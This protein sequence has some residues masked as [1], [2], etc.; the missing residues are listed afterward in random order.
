MNELEKMELDE[1]NIIPEKRDY[2]EELLSIIRTKPQKEIKEL[3]LDY[4][5]YDIASVI[6]LLTKE[7]RKK[8]YRILGIDAVS[9]VFAYLEDAAE[10]LAEVEIEKAADII[11][12]MDADDALD[13]L[14]E[15]PETQKQEILSLMDEEAQE[16]IK[17]LD[18]YDDD[19]IG[20]K[21]TTNFVSV[22]HTASVKQAMRSLIRQAAENDNIATIYVVDENEVFFGAIELR[23]LVIARE[24]TPLDDIIQP[25]YPY[26]YANEYTADCIE[27]LK[28]YSEDSIPVLDENNHLI[29]VITSSDVVEAVDEE[30]ADDYAKFAGLT[31]EEDLDEPLRKSIA[32][33]IPWLVILLGLGMLVA[34]VIGLFQNLIP[35]SLIIL[36]TFQSLILGMCGNSGTQSL[37]V[38]IRILSDD[39]L[40]FKDR[41]KFVFK[42]LKVGFCNGLI[43]GLIAFA[44]IGL[45]IQFVETDFILEYGVSGFAISAC[46]GVSLLVS[47][48][49]ASLDGTLI[50]MFFKRIGIDPAVA[51][52]PLITT[53]NDLVAVC[54][55]YGVSILLLVN[56]LGI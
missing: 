15:L 55:Y 28:D 51:S 34:G 47:M 4:H 36:Y 52:G 46:I 41:L 8:L 17:L 25:N 10:Y 21:M 53:I 30:L 42:E 26:L 49:I 11:E 45:Y 9:D 22:V 27:R 19:R 3:L 37:G 29:G 7:E 12:L 16:D 24:G 54:A 39:E 6:P 35:T 18:S 20:S 14:E 13:V 1:L 40:T 43:V 56:L 38:T 50:P 5:D 32:K 2:E 33:R 23:D 31:T 48:I 44:L